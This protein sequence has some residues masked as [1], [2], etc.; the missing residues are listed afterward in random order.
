M[1]NKPKST[2]LYVRVSEEEIQ[3]IKKIA[4]KNNQT[5]TDYVKNRTIPTT[6]TTVIDGKR[7][8]IVGY[9]GNYDLPEV[10]V[11]EAVK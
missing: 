10:D 3:T 8:K 1:G 5:V 7:R 6:I 4:K 11:K 9:R 2:R